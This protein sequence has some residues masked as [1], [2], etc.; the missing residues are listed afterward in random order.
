[1]FQVYSKVTQL[2]TLYIYIYIYIYV[3]IFVLRFLS[4]IGY[5]KILNIV[6]WA[7]YYVLAVYFIYLSVCQRCL[8]LG[9]PLWGTGT[10][11]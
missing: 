1:M 11:V 4:I 3:C 2:Y 6:P 9:F 7:I 8:F 10:R 5:Y